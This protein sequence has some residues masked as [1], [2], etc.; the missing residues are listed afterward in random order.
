MNLL[1]LNR[2]A[3]KRISNTRSKQIEGKK[4]IS[5]AT[6]ARLKNKNSPKVETFNDKRQRVLKNARHISLQTGKVLS[7]H[8]TMTTRSKSSPRIHLRKSKPILSTK[9]RQSPILNLDSPYFKREK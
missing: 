6:E 4:K 3:R 8:K 2:V 1:A 7:N 5:A 9:L